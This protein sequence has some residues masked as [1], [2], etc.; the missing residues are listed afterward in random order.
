M[1][2]EN[3]GESYVIENILPYH[4]YVCFIM[5]FNKEFS[6]CLYID[7]IISVNGYG[8]YIADVC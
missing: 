4:R 5:L 2:T 6:Y 3:K 8:H 7:L 1:T